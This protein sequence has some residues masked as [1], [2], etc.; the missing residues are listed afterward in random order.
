[1]LPEKLQLLQLLNVHVVIIELKGKQLL[2][3]VFHIL[4]LP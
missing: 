2:L 4:L 1:M 3:F